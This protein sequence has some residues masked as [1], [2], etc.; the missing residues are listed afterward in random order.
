MDYFKHFSHQFYLGPRRCRKHIAVKVNRTP[1]VLSF[2]EHFSPTASKLLD[3][4][5]PA[6]LVFFHSL[7]SAYNLTVS[8]LVDRNR[9]QN[10][11]IFKLSAPILA[12]VDPIHIDIRIMSTLQGTIASFLNVDV[13]FLIQLTN[14]GRRYFASPKSF[15]DVFDSPNRNACQIHLDEGFFHAALI[16]AIS[17][18]NGGLKRDSF[19]FWNSQGN[20]PRQSGK[21]AAIMTT[22]IALALFISLISSCLGQLLSFGL[23]QFIE[24]FFYASP[25]KFFNLPLDYFLI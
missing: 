24:R 7:G 11:Y 13:C 1:L 9:H 19:E 12:Q 16:A 25:N 8:V 20:L 23:Q 22:A 21:I 10:R 17:L 4:A 5:D 3:K 14:H 6:G 18:N 2:R 15:S